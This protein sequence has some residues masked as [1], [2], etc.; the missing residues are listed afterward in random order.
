MITRS[1]ANTVDYIESRAYRSNNLAA[2]AFFIVAAR[3]VSLLFGPIALLASLVHFKASLIMH[4][5]SCL[6]KNPAHQQWAEDHMRIAGSL[7]V[8]GL[9]FPVGL[10]QPLA[11]VRRFVRHSPS[12]TT[13]TPYGSREQFQIRRERPTNLEQLKGIVKAAGSIAVVGAGF[14][15]GLQA[16]PSEAKAVQICLDDWAD[17][18]VCFTAEGTAIIPAA[19]R[20]EEVQ[21]QL[22]KEGYA[23]K[24]AQASPVF[25]VGG[26]ISV[27]CHGWDIQSGTIGDTIKKI[28]VVDELGEER[29]LAPGDELFQRVV[30]GFGLH[31]VI[32][33]V[34]LEVADNIKLEQS[35]TEVSVEDYEDHFFG[36]DN[37]CQ[38]QLGRLSLDPKEWDKVV[39]LEYR[40][41]DDIRH[42]QTLAP[43]KNRGSILDRIRLELGRC[44]AFF[45]RLGFHRERSDLLNHKIELTR[46]D[47]MRPVIKAIFNDSLTDTEW[48]QEYFVPKGQLKDFLKELGGQLADHKVHLLNASIR[49]VKW[50]DAAHRPLLDYAPGEDHFAIVLFF[51]Q[52]KS[53][54]AIQETQSWV[55]HINE[56]LIKHGGKAYLP[57]APKITPEQLGVMYPARSSVQPTKFKTRFAEM[58]QPQIN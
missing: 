15:Q 42:I 40:S 4:G 19:M 50:Q 54:A 17:K 32:T 23:L 38:M 44:S 28:W 21:S 20:W 25:S 9:A 22:A 58:L 18:E 36:L 11:L 47:A 39:S 8:A 45:R 51:N 27:N 7:L 30:G 6:T 41:V 33:K 16:V 34:E 35:A 52:V 48:L 55:Q 10:I 46:N 14:S 29:E 53:E 31:G 24:V 3:L 57:Y 43:E 5:V 49:Y 26:S 1:L 37:A 2:K 12:E 13:F 56:W